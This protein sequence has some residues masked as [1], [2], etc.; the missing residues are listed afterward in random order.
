LAVPAH[1]RG[2]IAG[3]TSILMAAVFFVLL[4]ACANAANLLLARAATRR[5]EMAVRAALGASRG[6]L[7]RQLL[8][9][10]VMI[11]GLGG[12]GGVL[13]TTFIAPLLVRLIPEE[14]PMRLMLVMDWRV[15]TF[16][17]VV[18]LATGLI[19]GLAPAW[20]SAQFDLTTMLNAGGRKASA[21]NSWWSRALVVAQMAVCL[22]LLIAGTLCLRSLMKAQE[23]DLGFQPAGRALVRVD[24]SD[25]GYQEAEQKAF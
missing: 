25:F 7:I 23:L 8:T 2:M 6:R 1:A 24:L 11:A 13:L 16:A 4:I 18:S 22:I 3:F 9:E 12:S 14:I 17:A 10:S 5:A 19:F 20:R 15:Y 21:R